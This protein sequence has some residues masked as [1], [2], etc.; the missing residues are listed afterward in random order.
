MRIVKDQRRWRH[1]KGDLHIG[2]ITLISSNSRE[3]LLSTFSGVR[4]F[5]KHFTCNIL[6][7]GLNNNSPNP[8]LMENWALRC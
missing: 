7:S 8:S 4:Y 6:L 3:H 5:A 2:S 1:K